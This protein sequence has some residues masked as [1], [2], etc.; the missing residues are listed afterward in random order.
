MHLLINQN[1]ANVGKT[2]NSLYFKLVG[3]Y[4][5][6]YQKNLVVRDYE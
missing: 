4:F 6:S 5:Q 2:E 1:T 3:T